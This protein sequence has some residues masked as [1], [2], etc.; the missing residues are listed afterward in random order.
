F[1][2][3]RSKVRLHRKIRT[4]QVQCVFVVLAHGERATL[5]SVNPRS[6]AVTGMISTRR[7]AQSAQTE[8][9]SAIRRACSRLWRASEPTAGLALA[10]R[11]VYA[12]SVQKSVRSRGSMKVQ[13]PMFCGSSWHQTN[14]A[15]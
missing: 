12:I 1:R 10:S 5:A 3:A 9:A 11:P 13:A 7:Q 15:L 8:N 6:N 4:R 14:F 2:F